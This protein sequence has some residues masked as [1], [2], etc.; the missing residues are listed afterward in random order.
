MLHALSSPLLG[1]GGRIY[2]AAVMRRAEK[3]AIMAVTLTIEALY[4]RLGQL[5]ESAQAVRFEMG[6]VILQ[7]HRGKGQ[8]FADIAK[9]LASDF[10]NAR[11]ML[12]YALTPKNVASMAKASATFTAEGGLAHGQH[13][14]TRSD[15]VDLGFTLP[16]TQALS[17]RVAKGVIRVKDVVVAAAKARKAGAESKARANATARL[18]SLLS[19]DADEPTISNLRDQL[20]RMDKQLATLREKRTKLLA[21]IAEAEAQQATDAQPTKVR[22]RRRRERPTWGAHV[23]A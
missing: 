9:R 7:L 2:H 21:T 5:I 20:E 11:A 12:G 19:D 18:R 13:V 10:P 6:D 16:E 3:E 4:K 17:E 1:W 14:V 22:G 8:S 15:I 23:S